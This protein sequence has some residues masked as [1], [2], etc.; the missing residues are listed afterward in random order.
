MLSSSK[1]PKQCWYG[2]CLVE[3]T[4]SHTRNWLVALISLCATISLT[5]YRQNNL[6]LCRC[7][8]FSLV[9]CRIPSCTKDT[10]T[11]MWKF[12][13]ST[14]S[15]L[16][17]QWLYM[18]CFPQ[19]GLSV[20]LWGVTYCSDNSSNENFHWLPLNNN[21]IEYSLIPVLEIL[22]DD[23]RCPDGSLSL[24]L[25]GNFIKTTFKYLRKFLLH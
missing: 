15:A 25:F 11:W 2:F 13:V 1:L 18:C 20:N 12:Y 22:F 24:F 6:W 9:A 19:W 8:G 14:S 10:R 17:T 4:L 7:S 16:H 3:K 5:F 21:L 23:K